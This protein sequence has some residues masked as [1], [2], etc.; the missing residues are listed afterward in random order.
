MRVVWTRRKVFLNFEK[1]CPTKNQIHGILCENKEK[2][3]HAKI[4]KTSHLFYE[5]LVQQKKQNQNILLNKY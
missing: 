1:H 4:N 3:N 2:S 5:S